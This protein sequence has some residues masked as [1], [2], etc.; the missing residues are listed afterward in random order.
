VTHAL[1]GMVGCNPK[2]TRLAE[3]PM[4]MQRSC[5]EGA[6]ESLILGSP[7]TTIRNLAQ[8]QKSFD[9]VILAEELLSDMPSSLVASGGRVLAIETLPTASKGQ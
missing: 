9:A 8:Q 2:V 5:R 4:D 3:D 6:R 7:R 1:A